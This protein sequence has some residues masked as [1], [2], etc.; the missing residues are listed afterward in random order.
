M[1]NVTVDDND[2]SILYSPAGA[3][4]A[5]S[6]ALSCSA[7][8]AQPDPTKMVSGT[9][10]DSTFYPIDGG[11]HDIPNTPLFANLTFNGSAVYV[12]CALAESVK[13]PDGNSDM[14]FYVDGQLMGSFVKPALGINNTYEYQFPVFS[15]NSLAP[16]EHTLVLQNGHVNGT[17]SLVLLDYIV[18]TYVLID[19]PA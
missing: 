15:A 17:Q 19:T 11:T 14:A 1:I 4:N 8:T 5:R 6:A 7:C 2:H 10:H 3:W 16:G 9:W 18:Y 12:F 13:S